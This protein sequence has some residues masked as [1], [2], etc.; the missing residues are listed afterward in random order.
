[1][2]EDQSSRNILQLHYSPDEENNANVF[3]YSV[4]T[5]MLHAIAAFG[6]TPKAL[7]QEGAASEGRGRGLILRYFAGIHLEGLKKTTKTS[8]RIA[9]HQAKIFNPGPPEYEEG[10]INNRP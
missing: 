6:K 1:M 3:Y 2:S 10:V 8:V 5:L 7:L 4:T 9:Y